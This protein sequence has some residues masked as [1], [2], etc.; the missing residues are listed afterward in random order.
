MESPGYHC[1]SQLRLHKDCPDPASEGAGGVT[2]PQTARRRSKCW[3]SRELSALKTGPSPDPAEHK[4][5]IR[6]RQSQGQGAGTQYS[7]SY[8]AGCTPSQHPS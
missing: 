4:G 2:S 6:F 7:R 8:L 3:S 5:N 1:T